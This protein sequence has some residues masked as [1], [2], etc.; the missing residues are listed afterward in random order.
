MVIKEAVAVVGMKVD[1]KTSI[2]ANEK[3]IVDHE[4]HIKQS[5]KKK[6]MV[7]LFR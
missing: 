7:E 6:K 4:K 1:S 5:L 3:V 2:V